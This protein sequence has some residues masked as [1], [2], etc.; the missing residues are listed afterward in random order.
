MRLPRFVTR[1][2]WRRS[3]AFRELSEYAPPHISS[4]LDIGCGGGDFL[5]SARALGLEVHGVEMSESTASVAKQRGLPCESRG[6][7]SL[8]E[9]S[10][11]YDVVRL[12]DVLEHLEDPRR[13]LKV[14]AGILSPTGVAIIRVPNSEAMLAR[15]CGADWFPLEA[16]RHLWGFARGNLTM[17]LQQVGLEIRRIETSSNK[18]ILYFSLRNLLRSQ[19]ELELSKDPTRDWVNLCA[20]I[21]GT[22]DRADLGDQLIVVAQK[23]AGS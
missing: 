17:L 3:E 1:D 7:E 13:A 6:I 21:G 16:P 8:D 5:L 15:L 11:Q 2:P 14:I 18:Y 9:T 23:G 12:S 22:I 10:E 4:V 20:S 19:T